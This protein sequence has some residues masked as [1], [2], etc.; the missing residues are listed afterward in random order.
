M[1]QKFCEILHKFFRGLIEKNNLGIGNV[2]MHA[3]RYV[4]G[5]YKLYKLFTFRVNLILTCIFVFDYN[6]SYYNS[7]K[8][9]KE[10]F[11]FVLLSLFIPLINL[12]TQIWD[13]QTRYTIVNFGLNQPMSSYIFFREMGPL[14]RGN[15]TVFCRHLT[16]FSN[17]KLTFT[18]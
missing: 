5:Y 2:N 3:T 7:F 9:K 11:A 17:I 8:M 12:G 15:V 18:F 6:I 10:L 14:H 16:T 13:T 4:L 1:G